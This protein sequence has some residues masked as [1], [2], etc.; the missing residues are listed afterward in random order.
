MDIEEKR[1]RQRVADKK[2][3][4]KHLQKCR[5]KDKNRYKE[6]RESELARNK[7][8]YPSYYAKH[9]DRIRK[10]RKNRRHG[11]TQEWFDA[12][13]VE[14]NNCCSICLTPFKEDKTPHIDHDHKCCPAQ[15][16]CDKCRRDLLCDDCNLGLGRFKDDPEILALAIQYIRKHERQGNGNPI[17]HQQVR[18]S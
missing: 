11:I 18:P 17:Q 7:A 4:R 16:S 2:F 8:Y 5:R 13:V 9:G 10:E 15:T 14:Q 3:R 1:K 12:K 6:N